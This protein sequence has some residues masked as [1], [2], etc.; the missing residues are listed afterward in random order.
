MFVWWRRERYIFNGRIVWSWWVHFYGNYDDSLKACMLGS[1][2]VAGALSPPCPPHCQYVFYL[3]PPLVIPVSPL[4]VRLA[5]VKIF[6][7]GTT[8][9][10]QYEQTHVRK[11]DSKNYFETILKIRKTNNSELYIIFFNS[12]ATIWF[13]I[14]RLYNKIWIDFTFSLIRMLPYLAFH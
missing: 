9:Y 13:Q 7:V 1:R 5:L 8:R 4:T 3:C 14:T 10:V 11:H 6:F 2:K 12:D